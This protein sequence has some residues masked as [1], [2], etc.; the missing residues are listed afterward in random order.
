MLLKTK[1]ERKKPCPYFTDLLTLIVDYI[2]KIVSVGTAATFK[3]LFW[4]VWGYYENK[5][6]AT[7]AFCCF[8]LSGNAWLLE[9]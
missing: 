4:F 6:L 2:N 5:I 7:K 3:G 8:S 1:K 9:R